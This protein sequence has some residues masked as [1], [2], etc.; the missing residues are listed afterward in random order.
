MMFFRKDEQGRY[1][2][3]NLTPRLWFIFGR[4]NDRRW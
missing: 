4:W 2:V 3:L 1:F